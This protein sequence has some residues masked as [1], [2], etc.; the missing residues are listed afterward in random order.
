MASTN[1]WGG[2]GLWV[3][4]MTAGALVAGCHSHTTQTGTTPQSGDPAVPV[5]NTTSAAVTVVLPIG[6]GVRAEQLSIV[7]AL[8]SVTP[9]SSGAATV[10]IYAGNGSQLA[11]VLS[12]AGNPMLMGWVDSTH[13]SISAASTAAVFAYFALGGGTLLNPLDAQAMIAGIPAAPQ[14]ASLEQTVQSELTTN[15]DAFATANARLKA[16]VAA[17]ATDL[18]SAARPAATGSNRV[19]ANAILINPSSAQSGITPIQD[20]PF[21]AHLSNTFRR[22]AYAFVDRVSR[23]VGGVVTLDPATVT[24]FDVP[25]VAG[26]NGGVTGA[27][28]DIMN[29][30]YGNQPTAYGPITAPESGTFS[31]PLVSGSDRTT[32]QVTVVGPGAFSGVSNSLTTEQANALWEVSLR[33]F[34]KDFLVPTTA[35]ALLGSGVLNFAE[36]QGSPKAEF[37][38]NILASITADMT[39]FVPTI[40][41]LRDKIIAGKWFDA[42]VDISATAGGANT[43]RTILLTAVEKASAAYATRGWDP[44]AMRTLLQR[45]DVVMNAAG[46]G[47][48]AFDS[49][50]YVG[51]I[52]QSNR[53]DQWNIVATSST[54]KLN[55]SR[56]TVEA[57]S[58]ILL[59]AAV[60]GVDSLTGYSF[61]WSTTT[62]TVNDLT[63]F[64]GGNRTRQIDFCS[65]SPNV[66]YVYENGAV[67]GTVDTITVKVFSD[68][69]CESGPGEYLGDAQADVE[70][71]KITAILDPDKPTVVQLSKTSFTVG[72]FGTLPDGA[73]YQWSLSGPGSLALVDSPSSRIYTAPSAA[74][75]ATVSVSISDSVGNIV[76]TASTTITTT[77]QA[78]IVAP[79]RFEIIVVPCPAEPKTCVT[80]TPFA[81]VPRFEGAKS[82]STHAFTATESYIL[83]AGSEPLTTHPDCASRI[84]DKCVTT[85]EIYYALAG[86]TQP[87]GNDT[88]TINYYTGRFAGITIEVT[89]AF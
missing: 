66:L 63:E 2:S 77:K 43:L 32:Y 11:M 24:K 35:N 29:A 16:A 48:Q 67:G 74:G 49:G 26:V 17:F 54:V 81:I 28:T 37:V 38:A 20:P 50:V 39:A 5:L 10:S 79:G 44:G 31:T 30:Y 15:V 78:T 61:H 51:Q 87:A 3:M 73:T 52:S 36:G 34:L 57:G 58:N 13:T 89:V 56:S 84:V 82:Y 75:N 80:I 23:T 33:G 25:P 4:L 76:A 6:V 47:L 55:P 42:G 19:R 88:D 9:T 41:G 7:T 72:T 27:L 71:E 22:R 83:S 12:P 21:A 64:G 69:R 62:N 53:A 40:P 46:G 45:F 18:Y 86:V 14:I 1:L 70:V 85:S 68:A 60:P 8:G 59:T 65:S